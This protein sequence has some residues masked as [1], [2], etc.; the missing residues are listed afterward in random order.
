MERLTALGEC[1][2]VPCPSL[3]FLAAGDESG[4][5]QVLQPL[6]KH[7]LAQR[8]SEAPYLMIPARSFLDETED[9]CFP[10]AAQDLERELA[11]AVE[12]PRKPLFHDR[13]PI[14]LT[15]KT[16]DNVPNSALNATDSSLAS[17]GRLVR[18]NFLGR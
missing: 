17:G 1:V 7:L 10:F 5:E 4:V 9:D 3:L 16:T 11:R 12:E 15:I 18:E 13:P 6:G 14:A 8:R 2:H